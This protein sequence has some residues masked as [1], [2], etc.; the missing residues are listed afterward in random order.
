MQLA[1]DAQANRIQLGCPFMVQC[2]CCFNT[3]YTPNSLASHLNQPG[4]QV[5][6]QWFSQN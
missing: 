3:I 2:G 1:G 4:A 6:E 5:A